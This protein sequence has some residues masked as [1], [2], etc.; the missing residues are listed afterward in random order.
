[1]PS[2]D[3]LKSALGQ[4]SKLAAGTYEKVQSSRKVTLFPYRIGLQKVDT[5]SRTTT[6]FRRKF[7]MLFRVCRTS[8]GLSVSDQEAM[9]LTLE[10]QK[11]EGEC[12]DSL[13]CEVDQLQS[14]VDEVLKEKT[15]L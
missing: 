11:A 9:I 3:R 14:R 7:K 2:G 12:I 1:M 13:E 6:L 4:G 15:L 5:K 10:M 8:I